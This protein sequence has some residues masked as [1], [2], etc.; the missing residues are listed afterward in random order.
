MLQDYA[1]PLIEAANLLVFALARQA[2]L[3]DWATI[4]HEVAADDSQ[5]NRLRRNGG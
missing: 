5:D 3:V 1:A 2:L 4:V